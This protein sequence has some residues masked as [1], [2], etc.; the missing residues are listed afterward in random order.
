MRVVGR[1]SLVSSADQLLI[2]ARQQRVMYGKMRIMPMKKKLK[3][4]RAVETVKAMARE[5]IGA[6]KASRIVLGR[7]KKDEKHKPTLGKMLDEQ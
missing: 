4:F 6:P 3:K 5:R 1:Q 2:I 7:K